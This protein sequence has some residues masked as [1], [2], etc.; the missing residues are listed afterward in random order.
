MAALTETDLLGLWETGL[1][2]APSTRALTLAAAASGADASELADLTLGRRDALLLI[3]RRRCFGTQLPCTVSCPA[4]ADLLELALTVDDI[5]LD[6]SDTTPGAW[7]PQRAEVAGIDVT[8]RAPTCRDLL[9]V[10]QRSPDARRELVVSC[11]VEARNGDRQLLAG[12]LSE[13]VIDAVAERLGDA[14]PQAD[15]VVAVAC[16]SCG[17]PWNAPFDI[18]G[19]LWAEVDAYARRLLHEIQVLAVAFG[20]TE[21]DVLAVSPARRRFYLDGV[22]G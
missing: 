10:D 5:L 17:H 22:G 9:T 8:F 1:G 19:Y 15:V 16:P 18:A 13:E 4:C 12:A 2:Q 6:G 14:D 11:I 7:T 3:L 20:W 21:A